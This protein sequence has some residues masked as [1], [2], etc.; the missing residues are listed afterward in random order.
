MT[1]SLAWLTLGIGLVVVVVAY[2]VIVVSTRRTPQELAW[3]LLPAVL[4]A[5]LV[6]V[7]IGAAR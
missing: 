1:D 7:T 3:T 2:V 6:A 5:V 4:L